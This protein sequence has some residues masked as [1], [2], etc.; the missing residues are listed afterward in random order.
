MAEILR[1]D[2]GHYVEMTQKDWDWKHQDFK[3][4]PGQPKSCL[5]LLHQGTCSVPVKIVTEQNL[6]RVLIKNH[7]TAT[8]TTLPKGLQV[9]LLRLGGSYADVETEGRSYC[10]PASILGE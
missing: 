5:V 10:V 9:K 2:N 3:S 6:S 4:R 7:M 1:E 8:G